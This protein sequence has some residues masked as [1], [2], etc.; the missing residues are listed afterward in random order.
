MIHYSHINLVQSYHY[1]TRFF[2]ITYKLNSCYDPLL[3]KH[4]IPFAPQNIQLHIC[5]RMNSCKSNGL[6][7]NKTEHGDIP[8]GCNDAHPIVVGN[9]Q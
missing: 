9:T 2:C 6:V 8:D 4:P 1:I 3:K 7:L 5:H